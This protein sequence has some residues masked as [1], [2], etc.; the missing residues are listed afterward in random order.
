M[1]VIAC[2]LLCR[3]APQPGIRWRRSTKNSALGSWVVS[4][5]ISERHGQID[6]AQCMVSCL[7]PGSTRNVHCSA[8]MSVHG[9][10]SPNVIPDQ[11]APCRPFHLLM[12]TGDQLYNVRFSCS[13]CITCTP[14]LRRAS[15][16]TDDVVCKR[17]NA[18]ACQVHTF[19][20]CITGLHAHWPALRFLFTAVD[21]P[22]LLPGCTGTNGISW[23]S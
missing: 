12:G 1:P 18:A 16:S 14:V 17:R 20:P 13:A 8:V 5:D 3:L 22:S 19:W 21:A 23:C 10:Q 9:L 4:F 15:R 11:C 2:R 7:L 6:M